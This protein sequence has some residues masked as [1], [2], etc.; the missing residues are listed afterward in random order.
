METI[1]DHSTLIAALGGNAEVAR[2]GE[3]LAVTVGYWKSQNRIPPEYWPRII[4][5]AA[6]KGLPSIDS[7]WLM[8]RWPARKNAASAEVQAA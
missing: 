1:V 3:W 8:T 7:D 4:E 2:A 5:I 6:D